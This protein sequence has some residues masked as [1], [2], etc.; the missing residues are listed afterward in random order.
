MQLWLDDLLEIDFTVTDIKVLAAIRPRVV[1]STGVFAYDLSEL[2]DRLGYSGPNAK[3]QAANAM[4]H[5]V[6]VGLFK[7][8]GRNQLQLN[9]KIVWNGDLRDAG[10]ATMQNN[11]NGESNATY[12][13]R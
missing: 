10:V 1:P 2:A 11:L 8:L 4:R 13:E 6:K 12:E 3:Q 7:R 9:P 5:A